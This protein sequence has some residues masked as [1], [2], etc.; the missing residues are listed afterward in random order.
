MPG[1]LHSE[2]WFRF[3]VGST[4]SHE[5]LC[6][7]HN[8]CD[9]APVLFD[10]LQLEAMASFTIQQTSCVFGAG[11]SLNHITVPRAVYNVN[12]VPFVEANAWAASFMYRSREDFCD[13]ST[14][15][16]W[17]SHIKLFT[18]SSS[19]WSCEILPWDDCHSFC[20]FVSIPSRLCCV[21]SSLC[22]SSLTSA[23]HSLVQHLR[24]DAVY[25][26][27]RQVKGDN[28]HTISIINANTP[29][30]P[31]TLCLARNLWA[32]SNT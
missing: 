10:E 29:H 17:L 31:P 14:H 8:N 3:R 30:A 11:I 4:P 27:T 5:L 9:V 2:S 26:G 7:A 6:W 28:F 25:S 23:A 1:C 18:H 22:S 16:A 32:S 24:T 21:A 15:Q 13:N 12:Y 20:C 19:L